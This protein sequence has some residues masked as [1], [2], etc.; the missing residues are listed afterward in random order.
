[1]YKLQATN[2]EL[3]EKV[4]K[5]QQSVHEL[6]EKI[7]MEDLQ[8]EYDEFKKPDIDGDDKISRAEFNM[9]IQ[10]YLQNYPGITIDDFP[11]WEDFDK[12]RSGYITFEEYTQQMANQV[13]KEQKKNGSSRS[14]DYKL[15]GLT[16]LY[17]ET[18]YADDFEDLFDNLFG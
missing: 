14:N 4:R 11:K 1:M 17:K 10:N 6:E 9:Y 16:N 8:R 18:A 3:T 15:A 13:K 2:T 5:L 7:R 12:D